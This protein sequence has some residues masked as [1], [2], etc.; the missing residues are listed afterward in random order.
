MKLSDFIK[1]LRLAHDV[2][3]YYCNK[4]PKNCGY[5]DGSRFS[6][7]CWNLIK[8]ILGGWTDNRTPGYYVS[9]KNFPTGDCDGYTL[10]KKCSGRS[11]DFSKLSQPGTY[12]YLSTSPHAGVYLG[13]F[14]QDGYTFNVIECTGAWESKVQYTYVDEKGGRYLYKGGPKSQYSW[15][16]Y[17]LLT[18][19][20]D[21]S[22]ST[23]V[24]EPAPVFSAFAI[25]VSKHQKGLALSKAREEGFDHIIIRAGGGGNYADPLFEDFYNQAV[26]GDWKKAA[27][28]Y[29][30]CYSVEAALSEAEHFKSLLT[31]KNITTVY[32]DVEGNMLNQDKVNLTN[33]ILAFCNTLKAAGYNCGIYSSESHFNNKFV[34]EALKDIPHW[35]AAYKLTP[36]V[37]RSGNSYE[38]WQ[39]GGTENPFRSN[40]VAGIITDQNL[41]LKEWDEEISGYCINGLDYSPVFDSQFY[42]NNYED[43]RDAFGY[44][45]SALWIHFKQFGMNEFRQ[46]SAEFNPVIYKERY[47]DL[48]DAFGNNNPMYYFHYVAFGKNEGR[49]AI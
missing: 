6:F 36:P 28:Y 31:G 21:Y 37:L 17:G 35:V 18:P 19:Y 2:P 7:D 16:D 4:F 5:Y 32:Y 26:S 34:D 38:M 8:A 42:Y 9:P 48:V 25:D 49:S 46:A 10:L 44:N 1:Q 39:Y 13:D 12:L 15:T 30:N 14:D 11:R 22:N 47:S 27:Y 23:P 20:I 3:N 41:M 33:V 40:K 45:P 43:L 24:P 29:G